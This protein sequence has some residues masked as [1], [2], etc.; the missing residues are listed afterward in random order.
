MAATD[1]PNIATFC[2]GCSRNC[3]RSSPTLSLWRAT[4]LTMAT[5]RQRHSRPTTSFWTRPR[6]L[7]RDLHIIITAGNHDSASRLEAPRALLTRQRVEVRGHVHRTW[8]QQEEGG[9]WVIDYEDLMIPLTGRTGD[10][11]VVLAVPF[12]PERRRAEQLLFAGRH[13]PLAPTDGPCEGAIS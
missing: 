9:R 3:E 4:S 8:Q 13:G 12:L 1:C 5:H 6:R 10:R 7:V 11:V 2:N